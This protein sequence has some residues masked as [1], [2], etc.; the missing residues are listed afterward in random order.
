MYTARHRE[1][2]LTDEQIIT[3]LKR[4]LIYGCAI[5]SENEDDP[6]SAHKD[7]DAEACCLQEAEEGEDL[8][9]DVMVLA[10][11]R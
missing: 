7:L 1:F 4:W 8:D 2:A 11:P 3:G 9:N 6:L 5:T 10:P